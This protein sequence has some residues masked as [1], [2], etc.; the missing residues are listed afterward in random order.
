MVENGDVPRRRGV[1][2]DARPLESGHDVLGGDPDAAGREGRELV[3]RPRGGSIGTRV[4]AG[5]VD[6]RRRVE[7]PRV[8]HHH[9]D[10]TTGGCDGIFLCSELDERRDGRAA[11]AFALLVDASRIGDGPAPKASFDEV[12]RPTFEARER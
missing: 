10:E 11:Q 5:V 9:L 2:R 12:H 3:E 8:P 1:R 4:D 6:R 7:P